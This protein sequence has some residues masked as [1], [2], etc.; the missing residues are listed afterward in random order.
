MVTLKLIE[1]NEDRVI[2]EY[3]PEGDKQYPG[4]ISL[5]LKTKERIYLQESSKDFGKRYSYYAFMKI[6]EYSSNGNF[7]KEGLVAWY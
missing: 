3:Y 1:L 6:E 4:K 5:D 7:E 2:Y